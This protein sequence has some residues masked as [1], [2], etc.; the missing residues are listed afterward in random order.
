[1]ENISKDA[2]IS[3]ALQALNKDPKLRIR[4]AAA[5][6]SVP[7]TTIRDRR[8]GR[9]NRGDSRANLKKLTDSEERVIVKYILQLDSRGLPTRYA[10]VEDMANQL[11]S[12]VTMA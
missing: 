10:N 12:T 6:Y 4:K 8:D 5:I 3:L 9:I 7:P 11:Q 1:M 2:G